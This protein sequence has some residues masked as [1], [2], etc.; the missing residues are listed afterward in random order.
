V[1]YGFTTPHDINPNNAN[2]N[3]VRAL[4]ESQWERPGVQLALQISP[5][6][7]ALPSDAAANGDE[8]EMR[9]AYCEYAK[10]FCAQ[11]D[12]TVIALHTD[13]HTVDGRLRTRRIGITYSFSDPA[14]NQTRVERRFVI[15]YASHGEVGLLFSCSNTTRE[16][17][18]LMS[19]WFDEIA[20]TVSVEAVDPW[21]EVGGLLLFSRTAI[22]VLLTAIVCPLWFHDRMFVRSTALAVAAFAISQA[23]VYYTSRRVRWFQRTILIAGIDTSANEFERHCKLAYDALTAVF[24]YDHGR[25]LVALKRPVVLTALIAGMALGGWHWAFG[26]ATVIIFSWIVNVLMLRELHGPVTK[27]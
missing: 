5:T 16:E 11:H 24:A 25:I 6:R 21:D 2:T 14:T 20:G 7:S 17:F 8:L 10:D 27:S 9:A 1:P 18:R 13:F 23:A 3:R 15:P 22:S 26:I 19:S 12:A 4:F